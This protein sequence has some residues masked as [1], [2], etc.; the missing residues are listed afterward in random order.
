MGEWDGHMK[1]RAQLR[2]L[3]LDVVC[4]H[5]SRNAI[6]DE[7]GNVLAQFK[8]L[9]MSAEEF[10][11][12]NQNAGCCSSTDG[13]RRAIGLG[14]LIHPLEIVVARLGCLIGGLV[15]TME[16]KDLVIPP[17]GT[18]GDD[19]LYIM[20]TSGTSTFPKKIKGSAAGESYTNVIIC[21]LLRTQLFSHVSI[22]QQL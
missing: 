18:T 21:R 17:P 1:E 20:C 19:L 9:H 2:N 14:K 3:W 6:V 12:A 11:K 22:T 13:N 8:Q 7:H 5:G 4:R 15:W 16:D 10:A